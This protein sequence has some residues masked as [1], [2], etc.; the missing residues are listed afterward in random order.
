MSAAFDAYQLLA[1]GAFLVLFLGRAAQMYLTRGVRVFQLVRGKPWSEALLEALFLVTFPLWLLDVIGHAWPSPFDV[2][3]AALDPVL[4]D[5]VAA[6]GLGAAL[7]LVGVGLF[8]WSLT[9]FGTSWRVG[10][11]QR[12]PGA[13]V[14]HGVFAWSRNPIFLSMDLFLVGSFLLNGRLM[15]LLFA[16]CAIVGFHRQILHE[17][18]FLGRHHGQPYESYRTRV[19]RYLGRSERGGSDAAQ[20]G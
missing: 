14:T 15:M 2:V 11:D 20:H 4:I 10:V 8:A 19:R 16:A 13:L 7:Q 1:M 6:R 12:A 18:R 9:S 3:P 17:E 5:A